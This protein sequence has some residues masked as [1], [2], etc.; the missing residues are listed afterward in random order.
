[1]DKSKSTKVDTNDDDNNERAEHEAES[2][3]SA[4]ASAA[5][6]ACIDMFRKNGYKILSVQKAAEPYFAFIQWIPD[7]RE[8]GPVVFLEIRTSKNVP[9]MEPDTVIEETRK[10]FLQTTPDDYQGGPFFDIDSYNYFTKLH[11]YAQDGA[12]NQTYIFVDTITLS[13]DCKT[14]DYLRVWHC[15]QFYETTSQRYDYTRCSANDNA[16]YTGCPRS[17]VVNLDGKILSSKSELP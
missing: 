8:W 16:W 13:D 3:L 12:F 17:Y 9:H 7:E 15:C 11:K 6:E 2:P 14:F 10:F 1:M 4:G 5:V